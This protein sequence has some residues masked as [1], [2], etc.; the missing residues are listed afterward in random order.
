MAAKGSSNV[1]QKIKEF[2]KLCDRFG[3]IYPDIEE[4]KGNQTFTSPDRVRITKDADVS[5]VFGH[6][7]CEYHIIEPDVVANVVSELIKSNTLPIFRTVTK[8]I[9]KHEEDLQ[10]NMGLYR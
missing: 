2:Y 10:W 3:I 1:K 6:Y 8:P 7:L 4:S 9:G 5:H